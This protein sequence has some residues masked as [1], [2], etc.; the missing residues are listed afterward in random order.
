MAFSALAAPGLKPLTPIHHELM[1]LLNVVRP[2]TLA[3]KY[4]SNL[5]ER[6]EN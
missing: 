6:L 5:V 1:P 3:V 4:F 2:A